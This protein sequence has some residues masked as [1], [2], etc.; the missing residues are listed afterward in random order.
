MWTWLALAAHQSVTQC[1]SLSLTHSVCSHFPLLISWSVI[2]FFLLLSFAM[3]VFI[4]IFQFS[5]WNTDILPFIIVIFYCKNVTHLLSTIS[6]NDTWRLHAM[7]FFFSLIY[8]FVVYTHIES[9]KAF[10]FKIW[11]KRNFF[12]L[13]LSHFLVFGYVTAVEF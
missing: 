11:L 6:K 5:N 10:C 4:C 9:W 2:N 13:S 7:H 1:W 3:Y 8:C 12:F